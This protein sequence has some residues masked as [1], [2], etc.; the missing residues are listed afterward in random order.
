MSI[1]ERT[2]MPALRATRSRPRGHGDGGFSLIEVLVTVAILSAVMIPL[3]LWATQAMQRS[4]DRTAAD[5]NGFTQVSRFLK[6]DVP[7]ASSVAFPT[8]PADLTATFDNCRTLT[9]DGA[10]QSSGIVLALSRTEPDRAQLEYVTKVVAGTTQLVRQEC[11]QVDPDPNSRWALSPST[12]LAEDVQM[13]GSG[14]YVDIGCASETPSGAG[15]IPWCQVVTMTVQG[16]GATPVT[17]TQERRS[18]PLTADAEAESGLPIA[19]ISTEPS[20]PS[21]ARPLNIQFSALDS[22]NP[23]GGQLDYAWDL[24][25]D[26]STTESTDPT[27]PYTYAPDFVAP[28]QSKTYRVT[29]AVT[30]SLGTSRASV[31]VQVRNARPTALI[32]V[33]SDPVYRNVPV[34]FSASGSADPDGPNRKPATYE[35]DVDG[36]GTVD[37]DTETFEHT[38]TNVTL[39]TG[40][41]FRTFNVK[42]TV[43]DTDGARVT[44]TVPVQVFNNPPIAAINPQRVTLADF[45]R[46]QVFTANSVVTCP[47]LQVGEPPSSSCDRDGT[48]STFEWDFGNGQVRTG[49]G[50]FTIS[51]SGVDLQGNI[52][53]SYTV[54]LRV[55]DND[56][57]TTE[58][59]ALVTINKGPRAVVASSSVTSPG[60]LFSRSATGNLVVNGPTVNGVTSPNVTVGLEALAPAGVYSVCPDPL[61][62]TLTSSCDFDG[63]LTA[64]AW[65]WDNGTPTSGPAS[66]TSTSF[67]TAGTRTLQLQ[68]TDNDTATDAT[69]IQVKVNKA[70][71]ADYTQPVNVFRRKE[72]TL[73][74]TSTDTDAGSL[75]QISACNWTFLI[76][77]TQVGTATGCTAVKWT[78]QL[79]GTAT[80]RL[81]V[82]D[83][84]GGSNRK[85][86]SF[87]VQNQLPV[88]TVIPDPRAAPPLSGYAVLDGGQLTIGCNNSVDPDT[89]A[90][91][92][93][94][95]WDWGDGSPTTTVTQSDNATHTYNRAPSCPVGS[96]ASCRATY[97]IRLRVTD[98]DGGFTD[99]GPYIVKVNKPPTATISVTPASLSA[100]NSGANFRFVAQAVATDVDGYAKGVTYICEEKDLSNNWVQV[101]GGGTYV[102]NPPAGS[103]P[104]VWDSNNGNPPLGTGV[105]IYSNRGDKRIRVEVFDDDGAFAPPLAAVATAK[106]NLK[107]I[108]R[109]IITSPTTVD[110]DG[111]LVALTQPWAVTFVDD[112]SSDPD[113]TIASYKW[114]WNNGTPTVFNG[115][116]P[117]TQNGFS[118]PGGKTVTL[119]VTDNDGTVSDPVV[120]TIRANALP[121][122]NFARTSSPDCA[123]MQNAA[124]GQ[125]NPTSSVVCR[126]VPVVWDAGPTSLLPA[127]DG[128]SPLV[129]GSRIGGYRWIVQNDSGVAETITTSTFTRTYTNLGA[130]T[131]QLFVTDTDGVENPT[132]ITRNFTVVDALPVARFS[133]NP[134]PPSRLFT[135]PADTL[136][137]AFDATGS[138]DPDGVPA[139]GGTLTYA[140]D[141]GDG[142]VIAA[143]A[144]GANTL[145][146]RT[147]TQAGRYTATLTVKDKN[148]T[149]PAVTFSRQ[150]LL[151]QPPVA[152]IVPV[153]TTNSLSVGLDGS[154]SVDPLPEGVTSTLTYAWTI[155]NLPGTPVWSGTATGKTPTVV[156]PA[157]GNYSVSLVVKDQDLAT[158]APA[159]TTVTVNQ[160]PTAVIAG[161]ASIVLNTPYG[162]TFDGR[163]STDDEGAANLTYAW[164][165][166]D[167]TTSNSSNPSKTYTVPTVN[168]TRTVTLVVTDRFFETSTATVT[169]K[170]NRPPTASIGPVTIVAERGFPTGFDGGGSADPD[171]DS[172][173]LTFAWN[174]GEPASGAANSASGKTPTHTFG[175]T[176]IFTVTLT[177]TDSDGGV[178]V[179]PAIRQVTVIDRAPKA[180]FTTVPG[181]DPVFQVYSTGS[182]FPVA[183]DATGSVDPYGVGLQFQWNFGDGS[184]VVPFGAQ[185]TIN[186]TYT[187][188]GRYTVV[189]T[190]RDATTGLTST[191]S[192]DVVFNAPP[193]AVISPSDTYRNGA[194]TTVAFDGSASTDP[195]PDG[196]TAALTY[197]WDFGDPS[198]GALNNLTTRQPSHVYSTPGSYAVTL[199]VTDKYGT[200]SAVTTATVRVNTKPTA[201]ISG[202][203]RIV[204]NPPYSH[205]FDGRGSIDDAGAANLTYAWDFG[206]GTT[207]AS[208]NPSKIFDASLAGTTVTVTLNV[209]DQFSE[210]SST[211]QLVKINAAPTAVI[212]PD[213]IRAKQ[214]FATFFDGDASSDPDGDS[215]NLTFS[216]NFGDPTSGAANT[217]ASRFPAHVYAA[218]GSYT[219]LLTVTDEDTLA[220]ATV[221]KDISVTVNQA[222]TA[223][224]VPLNPP[225]Y[226]NVAVSFDGSPSTDTDGIVSNWTWTFP[227]P[228]TRSGKV[229]NYTFAQLGAASASLVV[230]DDNGVASAPATVNF[231]VVAKDS[232][233]D[234][235]EDSG[236]GGNDCNDNDASINPGAPDSLDAARADTN[237][238]GYDGVVTDTIFV[239]TSGT[240]ALG[241]PSA[242]GCGAPTSPCLAIGDGI[243]QARDYGR[244]T[245]LVAGG[246]YSRFSL[247]VGAVTIRGGYAS[248][249]RPGGT[250]TTRVLGSDGFFGVSSAAQFSNLT[251]P[252]MVRDLTFRG[253]DAPA[254]GQ[255]TYG[256]VIRQGGEFLTLK[257]VN[258]IGGR[259]GTGRVGN[260]GAS[261]STAA[262]GSG[263]LGQNSRRY[264][265][266]VVTRPSG[267]AAQAGT[268]AGGAG[269]QG[270]SGCPT[271]TSANG[272]LSGSNGSPA[273]P[274]NCSLGGS[275]GAGQGGGNGDNGTDGALGCA[276]AVGSGGGAGTAGLGSVIGG[277]WT[278][279]GMSVGGSG[280]LGGAGSGGGGGGGGGGTDNCNGF[281]CAIFNNGPDSMGAGGG[282]GG[283]GGTTAAGA[284]TGGGAGGASIAVLLD[285]TRPVFDNVSITIGNG[286][287]GGLGG[288]GGLGQPGGA[289]GAGGFGRCNDTAPLTGPC[290]TVSGDGG[291]AGGRGGSGGRGGPSGAGGGGAGGPA[292]GIVATGAGAIPTS[293]ISGGAA[294]AGGAGGPAASGGTAGTAGQAGQRSTQVTL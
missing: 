131:A 139:G 247:S 18:E 129:G 47:V 145:V 6:R 81:D 164:D 209:T 233:G 117:H 225:I 239:S 264:S 56:G 273:G 159:V 277:V 161:P 243:L 149:G 176:G 103:Y 140:W 280:A 224:I 101:P 210:A 51:Y 150:V 155:T 249:F 138:F 221:P 116:G 186:H 23:G 242:G 111:K 62:S 122:P 232:D 26:I 106:V 60:L 12:D 245:V 87:Q 5:A 59:T 13:L 68:V 203:P 241:D 182:T 107:P 177:V 78:P 98:V 137:V 72:I 204:L 35:W 41:Q 30:N 171:G 231:T 82:T 191:A 274:N 217:S 201:V 110:A 77:S 235:Y 32:T 252:V 261:A 45:G 266:C 71:V 22:V 226:R 90:I 109:G 50:P 282:A 105:C 178:S 265:G 205:N 125:P 234:G 142:T 123:A 127:A 20:P 120:L 141:F 84:E 42:L 268:G 40:Q 196:D 166:G 151:N 99:W 256:V 157:R 213:P 154:P 39:P 200:P 16:A 14:Q 287:N 96:P 259:G 134:E 190:V 194:P 21:G 146:N 31:E 270:D 202:G 189:L 279:A 254:A 126:G 229:V 4:Q 94:C 199:V 244:S 38:Y 292:I 153:P 289:G 114:V 174:F 83:S 69:Q 58:S 67:T 291:G 169:V 228:A 136:A 92:M 238:D 284:G 185:P 286:G 15:L 132:G 172:N 75:P 91:P 19:R 208:P 100:P 240:L 160:K 216:W 53:R 173:A 263:G 148:G 290:T 192:R 267:G 276:G 230:K 2:P 52:V 48:I 214:N 24:D 163:G 248:D 188:P 36:D 180:S 102:N 156:F 27:P 119:T 29:L 179:L 1:R 76:G 187:T 253:A 206:D 44:T 158:S 271:G 281:L 294:G 162:T 43:T 135:G 170:L 275:G 64:Y 251:T 207:S 46:S 65:S 66:S 80:V 293:T 219:V 223:G 130:R 95:R 215:A 212:G 168:T 124:T 258:I 88:V 283:L 97:Q 33:G 61:P 37:Y 181:G 3:L 113:G 9:G 236:T 272:G 57:Q 73:S 257:D 108:A 118:N 227:G 8:D 28:S 63:T 152:G 222:P 7:S 54:T 55:T 175:S 121:L 183:F 250:G 25:G 269:G 144:P 34:Q 143:G 165:F 93:S 237:C 147:Y 167:G 288:V 246:D 11:T 70:P 104:P 255:T 10:A 17:L 218:T 89:D 220:S 86:R 195:N 198:S 260:P 74:S 85:E 79:L 184:P 115:A 128:D 262:A 211:T 49:A 285:G 112:G 193:I 278:P 133:V 197:A